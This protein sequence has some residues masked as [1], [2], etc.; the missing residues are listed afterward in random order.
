[1]SNNA[2]LIASDVRCPSPTASLVR[3]QYELVAEGNWRVPVLWM[4]LFREGDLIGWKE[5]GEDNF[6]L[7]VES[8]VVSRRRMSSRIRE[9]KAAVKRLKSL[10]Y[11]CLCHLLDTF[12]AHLDSLKARRK[13]IVCE[14]QEVAGL[15]TKQHHRDMHWLLRFYSGD[16]VRSVDQRFESLCGTKL[17]KRFQNPKTTSSSQFTEESWETLDSLLGDTLVGDAPWHPKS[18][19]SKE[20]SSIAVAMHHDDVGAVQRM[21][22]AGVK[23]GPRDVQRAARGPNVE[24]L[25]LLLEHGG[26]PNETFKRPDA[27]PLVKAFNSSSKKPVQNAKLRLLLEHGAD[28]NITGCEPETILCCCF[29]HGMT[30]AQEIIDKTKKSNIR[31]FLK[32]ADSELGREFVRTNGIKWRTKFVDLARRRLEN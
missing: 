1:M 3:Q 18:L 27:V 10:D 25:R 13:Y 12:H 30:F 21:L 20:Y 19:N 5:S 14:W 26:D 16:T 22:A 7:S 11:N 8:P 4:A 32:F 31:R 2:Y 17:T 29:R 15:Q 6:G 24:L 28:P 23:V 9:A